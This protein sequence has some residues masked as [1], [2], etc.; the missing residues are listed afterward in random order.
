MNMDRV[1]IVTYDIARV[2]YL[3]KYMKNT[4]ILTHVRVE[5][6]EQVKFMD[7]FNGFKS[8]YSMLRDSA[9][10]SI[11]VNI[12]NEI[13]NLLLLNVGY[14][15]HKVS[16]VENNINL[17]CDILDQ[18]SMT[19][20]CDEN[21]LIDNITNIYELLIKEYAF[22]F[23]SQ[24]DISDIDVE[25][26]ILDRGFTTDQQDAIVLRD[27]YDY[28][29]GISSER[30]ML[31]RQNTDADDYECMVLGMSYVQRGINLER[32]N[33]KTICMAAPS[34]DLFYD[35]EML[36]YVLKKNNSSKLRFCIQEV[37]PYELWYDM[38]LGNKTARRSMY[39][40][41]QTGTMHHFRDAKYSI[42]RFERFRKIFEKLFMDELVYDEYMLARATNN[43]TEK[44][45]TG[46]WP[47]AGEEEYKNAGE[48]VK[49]LFD[50]PYEDTFKENVSILDEEL[51][52]LKEH[53]IIPVLL[54]PPYPQVYRDNVNN[55]MY[56]RTMEVLREYKEKYS[57]IVILNYLEDR[58]FDDYYFSDCSHLNYWG[59]NLLS[60]K[61]NVELASLE[62]MN[63]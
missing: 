6:S 28:Y 40:Y 41:P 23:V 47:N 59:S 30:Y 55:Q 27:Y 3:K 53:G 34:Q 17:L 10:K 12:M 51:N 31:L 8:K 60:D 46:V 22:E 19:G 56:Q 15:E 5:N 11:T 4:C 20:D 52:I 57:D 49:K 43:L 21:C 50:K 1:V 38:S 32:L 9:D 62:N 61:L 42:E 18:F 29:W 33:K 26:K 7:F 36:K 35:N 58:D 37:A 48:E 13:L 63:S 24:E 14:W 54:I 16:E 44:K 25:Y 2:V 39:Y 45:D